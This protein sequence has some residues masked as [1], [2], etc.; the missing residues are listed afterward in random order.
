[1][2]NLFKKTAVIALVASAAM[3]G[4]VASPSAFAGS[5]TATFDVTLTVE[6][7]CSMAANP[8]NFG[9]TGILDKN[10]DQS[11]NLSVSCTKGTPYNVAL[12]AGSASGSTVSQR[13]MSNA[14]GDASVSFNLYRD[15]ARTQLW[16]MTTDTD[17]VSGT[18]TGGEQT[19][20]VYG[21][22]PTQDTPAP[23]A[24]SS[25]ITATVVF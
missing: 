4:A 15:A 25:T 18:G 23:G 7:D 20:T 3:L 16:G 21:R 12:D 13:K 6:N 9:S 2:R 8:L 24:Y 17:T 14:A 1:M 11:G 10:L 22:V 5:K 19:H